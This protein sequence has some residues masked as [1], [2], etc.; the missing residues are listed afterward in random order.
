MRKFEELSTRKM[1]HRRS[2]RSRCGTEN[3]SGFGIGELWRPIVSSASWSPWLYAAPRKAQDRLREAQQS[4]DRR[5]VLAEKRHCM[6]KTYQFA[7]KLPS[8]CVREGNYVVS[9][10][11]SQSHLRLHAEV[12]RLRT[13]VQESDCALHL[14]HSFSACPRPRHVQIVEHCRNGRYRAGEQST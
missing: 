13:F 2:I 9:Y 12:P 7:W 8:I 4:T 10:Y 14:A 3:G 6:N 1:L 5:G 11:K